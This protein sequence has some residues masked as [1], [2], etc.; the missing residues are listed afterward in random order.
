MNTQYF[1]T[2]PDG[3]LSEH[4]EYLV[5]R[6]GNACGIEN[7]LHFNSFILTVAG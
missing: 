5:Q 4:R 3:F 2:M 1:H 7:I 6:Q